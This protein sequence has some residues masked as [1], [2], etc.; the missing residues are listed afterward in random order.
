[1]YYV[2]S[3]L[4]DCYSFKSI[5][6]LEPDTTHYLICDLDI[7]VDSII[8]K[9]SNYR[10]NGM[11]VVLM[12][13]DP[14]AFPRVDNLISNNA[15]DKV[16]V[17]DSQFKDRFSKVKTFVSDYFFNEKVFPEFDKNKQE[18]KDK[19]CVFGH[20]SH[21]RFNDFNLPQVDTLSHIKSYEDLYLEVQKYNG[22]AVY[23]TGL[24]EN[25]S[26]IVTYNKAKAVESLM[27]GVNP[28]CKEGIK[29]KRYDRFLKKYDDIANVKSIDFSQEEIFK[30]NDLTI[31]ELLF[32]CEY[33]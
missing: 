6:D 28:Y 27:C 7:S 3:N 31:R 33:I 21:G 29:T 16:I 30:I 13:F 15:L 19:V 2:L 11:K 26:R 9:L 32:E 25:R 24:C 14:A 17:F 10:K 4:S 5:S 20:L 1:M 18:F 8:D 22:V 12:V 23:D